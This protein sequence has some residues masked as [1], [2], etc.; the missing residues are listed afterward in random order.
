[1]LEEFENTAFF[2]TARPT[3]H[4][5]VMKMEVSEN[6]LQ[7]RGIWKCQFSILVCAKHILKRELVN[8]GDATLIMKFQ[9]QNDLWLT[10]F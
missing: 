8:N 9:I 10:H 6:T 7:T 1:M 2:S 4:N 5:N 3:V